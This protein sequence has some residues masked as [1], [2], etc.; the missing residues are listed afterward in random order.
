MISNGGLPSVRNMHMYCPITVN[1]KATESQVYRIPS[2]PYPPIP[3][4]YLSS[5]VQFG[6][7]LLRFDVE[8]EDVGRLTAHHEVRALSEQSGIG[9]SIKR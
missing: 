7:L 8:E 9:E 5:S 1:T 4:P 3:L 2:L 6:D